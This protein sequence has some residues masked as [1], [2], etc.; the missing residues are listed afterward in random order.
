MLVGVQ[1]G[2]S[3]L[4]GVQLCES[5]LVGVQPC[6]SALVCVSRCS[7]MSV[8]VSRCST[9]SVCV[10]L[11]YSVFHQV[12]GSHA[13]YTGNAILLSQLVSV[14]VTVKILRRD[15]STDSYTC[16]CVCT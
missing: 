11:C 10:S 1:P 8:C 7:T 16:T 15:L 12:S 13:M 2:Q 3:V 4:V 6:Q 9:M 5:V 14:I